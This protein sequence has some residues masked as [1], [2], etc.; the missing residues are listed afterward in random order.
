MPSRIS[1]PGSAAGS[2]CRAL[3]RAVSS[4]RFLGAFGGAVLV[5]S[6]GWCREGKGL[7]GGMRSR[8]WFGIPEEDL[9]LNFLDAL[10]TASSRRSVKRD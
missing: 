8:L 7:W 3:G 5:Q 9:G 2:G 1:V 10:G 6:S 4:G